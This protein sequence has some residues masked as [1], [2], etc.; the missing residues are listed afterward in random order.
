[1]RGV[2]AL[3]FFACG[4]GLAVAEEPPQDPGRPDRQSS[5]LYEEARKILEEDTAK[6]VELLE[7]SVAAKPTARAYLLLGNA[8]L[9]LQRV[10]E[11]KRAFERFL[12]LDPRSSRR[13]R[14]KKLLKGLDV[15]YSARLVLTTEPPG[16]TVYFDFKAAGARGKTPLEL[17]VSAGRH[18]VFFELEGYDPVVVKDVVIKEKQ[19]ETI[20]RALVYMGCDLAVA[21]AGPGNARVELRVDGQEPTPVP[22]RLRVAAGAH[23]L[24]LSGAGLL[25]KTVTVTCEERRP[26]TVNETL[27]PLAPPPP[28]PALVAARIEA[29]RQARIEVDR[30]TRL[31]RQQRSLLGVGIAFGAAAVLAEGVALGSHFRANQV[32]DLPDAYNRLRTIQRSA[33]YTGVGLGAVAVGSFIAYGVLEYRRETAPAAARRPRAGLMDLRLGFEI[34]PGGAALSYGARF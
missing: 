28:D 24:E 22:A 21:A 16:A 11:A 31:R 10:E 20:H 32:R 7:A 4:L 15:S 23:T 19:R 6:A 2:A 25:P 30:Q 13:D 34:L 26:L 29:E 9:R 14:V 27:A 33:Q 3:V 18:R 8:Y 12:E 5:A 17:P 1:M